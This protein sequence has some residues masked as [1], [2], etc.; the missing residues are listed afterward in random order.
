VVLNG[1]FSTW[2]EVLSGVPQGSV[3][4]PLLFVIFINDMDAVVQQINILRKFADDTKLGKTVVTETDRDELQEA[5]NQLCTWA[6][7]WG[8]QFNVA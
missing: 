4:G 1:R 6:D 2:E 7:T 8:M 5:L 3:L